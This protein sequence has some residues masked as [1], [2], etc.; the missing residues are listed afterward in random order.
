M[1]LVIR[2]HK[3]SNA[4]H[5][6]GLRLPSRLVDAL[7]RLGFAARI[8]GSAEIDP[9]AHF[10][11]SALA[12]VVTQESRIGPG[13]MI[14]THVVLGSNWPQPGGPVI[15]EGAIIHAGAKVLGPVRI[16]A[17][18]I[19]AANAVVLEDVPPRCLAAGVPA[20][21][22]RRDIDASAYR[23]PAVAASAS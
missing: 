12:V 11:H 9:T 7:I 16:G 8:P 4:L 22:K 13:V 2:L 19:V 18:S 6:R 10:S 15:E 3:I 1:Q 14:G 23:Y 21:I 17:G 5:R 20:V